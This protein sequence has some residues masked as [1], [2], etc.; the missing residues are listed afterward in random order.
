ME[1]EPEP[2]AVGELLDFGTTL[3]QDPESSLLLATGHLLKPPLQPKTGLEYG[4]L[5]RLSVLRL[6]APFDIWRSPLRNNKE[7]LWCPGQGG[8]AGWVSSHAPKGRRFAF[9][10]GLMPG[11]PTQTLVGGV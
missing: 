2:D 3:A 7:E 10:S 1:A 11:L 8:S 5:S 4:P 9:W 6:G